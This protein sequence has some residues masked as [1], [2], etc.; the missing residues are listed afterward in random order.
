MG[1]FFRSIVARAF[2]AGYVVSC[3]EFSPSLV[4]QRYRFGTLIVWSKNMIAAF[5]ASRN[6]SG[7]H[8]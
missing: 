3:A 8:R 1:R 6:V 5:V 7:A 4:D 2:T